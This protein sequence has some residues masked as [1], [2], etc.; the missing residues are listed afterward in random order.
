[1]NFTYTHTF[2]TLGVSKRTFEEIRKKLE[3][4]AHGHAITDHH[5]YGKVIDMHGLAIGHIPKRKKRDTPKRSRR[6]GN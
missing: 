4:A 5:A 2:V 1:M 3:A 6:S